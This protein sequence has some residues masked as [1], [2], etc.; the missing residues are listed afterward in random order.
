MSETVKGNCG[1]ELL[2]P[3]VGKLSAD[4]LPIAYRQAPDSRPTDGHQVALGAI[5]HNY[6]VKGNCVADTV[7]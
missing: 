2:K 6:S 3:T 5:P 7:S 4:S 1:E